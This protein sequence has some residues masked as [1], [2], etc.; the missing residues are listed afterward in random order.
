MLHVNFSG[1][2]MPS[3]EG[4]EN[5]ER[6]LF[7][8]VCLGKPDFMMKWKVKWLNLVIVQKNKKSVSECSVLFSRQV[9]NWTEFIR[10]CYRVQVSENIGRPSVR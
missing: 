10:A 3:T 6:K 5:T 2:S 4:T 8:S 1:E 7:H 9:K